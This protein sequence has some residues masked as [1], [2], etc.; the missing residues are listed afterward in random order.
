MTNTD[1]LPP[2]IDFLA[3]DYASFRRLMLD[4]L[5]Q[6]V[7][8]WREQSPADLGQALVEA[9]AYAADY[10]SYYQDA[11]ATE[12]YL[13]TARLRRSVRR[14]VRPL[15][16][17][18]QEGC[19][20]RA[21]VQIQVSDPQRADEKVKLFLPVHTQLLTKLPGIDAPVIGSG[22]AVYQQAL[23]DKAAVFET[24]HH[25]YLMSHH[26]QIPIVSLGKEVCLARGSTHAYLQYDW[27][28]YERPER[29]KVGDVLVLEE[30]RDPH[31]GIVPP[32]Y[33]HPVRLTRITPGE[34]E[35]GPWIQIEWAAADALPFDLCIAPLDAGSPAPRPSVALGNIVLVDHGRRIDEELPVVQPGERYRPPLHYPDLTFAVPYDSHA[36]REQSAY[37]ALQYHSYEAFAW[38]RLRQYTAQVAPR[39]KGEPHLLQ[40]VEKQDTLAFGGMEVDQIMVMQH[41]WTLQRDLLNSGPFDRDFQVEMEEDRR[42]YLRFGFEGIGK[43]PEPGDRFVATYRTGTGSRGNV[44]AETIAHV[45]ERDRPLERLVQEVS[46]PL[47]AH[48]GCDPQEIQSA[49]LHAPYAFRDRRGCVTPADYARRISQHPAVLHAVAHAR[50]NGN[51]RTVVIC[52]QR[53]SGKPVDEAFQHELHEFIEPFRLMG[54]DV[55][56]QSPVYVSVRV[57]LKIILDPRVAASL[58]QEGLSKT[59]SEQAWPDGEVGFFYPD[60]FGFGQS[61]HQSQAVARA[62][63]VPGVRRVTVELFRRADSELDVEEIPIESREIIRL[64]R[65]EFDFE[66]GL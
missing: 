14:H 30:R 42:A 11:V 61:I 12:A 60:R 52:V 16:Y 23:Q 65:I 5:S 34:S 55:E 28:N 38:I 44:G 50:W 17:Y 47:P 1:H 9:L 48:G 10:L 56:I 15:E 33:R 19:N 45:V 6:L 7:P 62:M 4:H 26:N 27:N 20:A 29:L 3:K 41:H 53:L 24:M 58:V 21:W 2:E 46:N 57:K 51:R 22:E 32:G 66:G 43:L 54:W 31:T 64:G 49:R 18:L 63:R 39:K 36:A 13:G 25:I 35:A 59:F 40:R 8:D 37:Q